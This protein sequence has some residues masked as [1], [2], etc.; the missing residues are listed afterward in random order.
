MGSATAA[1]SSRVGRVKLYSSSSSVY[2]TPDPSRAVY[3]SRPSMV[4]PHATSSERRVAVSPGSR[5]ASSSP[6]GVRVVA[7]RTA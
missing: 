4:S 7:S 2:A 5:T 6:V 1:Q 3:S